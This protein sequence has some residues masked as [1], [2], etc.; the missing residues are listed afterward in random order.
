ML[1]RAE[2]IVNERPNV[3]TTLQQYTTTCHIDLSMAFI[4]YFGNLIVNIRYTIIRKKPFYSYL[5][6]LAMII[7]KN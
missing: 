3:T 7:D 6:L 1:P 4:F 5:Y 2:R